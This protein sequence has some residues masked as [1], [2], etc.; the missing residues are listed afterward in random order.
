MS[1]DIFSCRLL[2]MFFNLEVIEEKKFPQ[3]YESLKFENIALAECR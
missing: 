3:N 2:A 1:S